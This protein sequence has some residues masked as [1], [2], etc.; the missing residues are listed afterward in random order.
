MDEH[1]PTYGLL[2]I[3]HTYNEGNI[4]FLEWMDLSRDWTLRM[5]EQYDGETTAK[6]S[7][8]TSSTRSQTVIE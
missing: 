3:N 1:V 8:P 4:T 7:P 6:S 2:V 5:I